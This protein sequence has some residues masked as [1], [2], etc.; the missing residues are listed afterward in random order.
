MTTGTRRDYYEIL[1]VERSA[2]VEEIKKAYR[3][4]AVRY[5]PDKN[6]DNPD[7][8][9]RFKEAS[10]AYAVLSDPEKRARYD[11]FGHEG[12][13]D[14]GFTGFDSE[15]FVDF[16]DILGDLF[17]FGDL[18]GGR[19]RTSHRAQRGSDL[20]FTMSLTLE[21]A[22]R[23][24]TK[25]IRVPR[26]EVCD[27]CGGSGVAGGGSP[28]TCPTCGGRG[29]VAYRR[30]F[31]TVAQ[32]CPSCQG[33]GRVVRNPCR[34]CRGRGRTEH[35]VSLEVKIPPGVD[36]SM[37]LRLSGEGESGVRGGPPGDLY[38]VVAVEAHEL[39]TRDGADLHMTLPVSVFQA[40]LGT[41]LRV[42]TILGEEQEIE[43]PAGAQPGQVIRVRGK[44]MPVLES[45]G[46]GDLYVHLKVVIP[47][48]LSPEQRRLIEEAAA[49][50]GEAVRD[51]EGL[52]HRIRRRLA[53]DG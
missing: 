46:T 10:E 12:L 20:R 41:R 37:R 43:I 11:R 50:G 51:D 5:H 2:G 49:H 42:P 40:M 53:N 23:G 24:V 35:E 47:E 30:G 6:P 26:L 1:G 3:R 45:R 38:V 39:F 44:G 13:G 36:N 4:M 31:L 7:A 17:G 28:E 32:T 14:V 9:E 19:R 22:A 18:F 34:A 29:Q 8:E 48:R 16:A 33:H 25:T 52:L 21:E 15:S 27:E